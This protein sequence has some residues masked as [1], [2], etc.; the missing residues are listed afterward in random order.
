M[1]GICWGPAGG[2]VGAGRETGGTG[3]LRARRAPAGGLPEE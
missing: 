3:V 2:L 1:Q